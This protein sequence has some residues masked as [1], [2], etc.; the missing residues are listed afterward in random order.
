MNR[1]I[2]GKPKKQGGIFVV[3]VSEYGKLGVL[4]R[5]TVR[6]EQAQETLG[7]LIADAYKEVE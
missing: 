6:L 1:Y 7:Y 4:R 2:F 3:E 5:T